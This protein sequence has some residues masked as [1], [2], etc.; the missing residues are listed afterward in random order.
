MGNS[1][2]RVALLLTAALSAAVWSACGSDDDEP[3]TDRSPAAT[4]TA[5]GPAPTATQPPRT[6]TADEQAVIDLFTT[7]LELFRAGEFDAL[8]ANF[9]PAFRQQCSQEALL[10]SIQATG[11]DPDRLG[12]RSVDA[13]VEGDTARVTYTSLYDEQAVAIVDDRQPDVFTR[14]DGR[15][16]DELDA[17]TH[18]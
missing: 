18:C 5:S 7:Q 2:A 3:N 8:Y 15:W 17:H 9:S 16:Y 6:P 4:R 10:A 12:F 1:I 11:I 14:V 13:V